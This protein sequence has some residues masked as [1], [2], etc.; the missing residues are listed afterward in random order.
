V[1]CRTHRELSIQL[2][3][4][5]L[6]H[7]NKARPE[8]EHDGCLILDGV[9]RDCALKIRRLAQ[10]LIDEPARTNLETRLVRG[11]EGERL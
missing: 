11:R 5:L 1:D 6:K 7:A 4:L 9:M 10:G 3:E 8:C 2:S